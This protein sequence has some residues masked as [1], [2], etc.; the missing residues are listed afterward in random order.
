MIGE[1]GAD[2]SLEADR[3]LTG[4]NTRQAENNEQNDR[5]LVS[6]IHELGPVCMIDA[7]D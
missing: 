3:I 5:M 2:I 6:R 7:G 4:R 1:N